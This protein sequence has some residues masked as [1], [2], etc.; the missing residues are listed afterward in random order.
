MLIGNKKLFVCPITTHIDIK[1]VSKKLK[2][3][4]YKKNC[5]INKWFI[6]K[7]R[8]NQKLLLWG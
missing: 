7:M 3:G 6:S 1:D 5:K 4:N 8:K 2:K